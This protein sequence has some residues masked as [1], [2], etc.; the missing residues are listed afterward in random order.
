M[1][2]VR[3][4]YNSLR[5]QGYD[6][7][8][9]GGYFVTICTFDR[10]PI[11]GKIV[12][13]A[14]RL[15][16]GGVIAVECWEAIPEH[17]PTVTLDEFVVMPDHIHGIL[18][19]SGVRATPASPL[20]PLGPISDDRSRVAGPKARSLGVVVGSFKSAVTRR[21]NQTLRYERG[22][23]WQRNYFERVIRHEREMDEIRQYIDNNPGASESMGY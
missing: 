4:R 16:A 8:S 15:T 14:T 18:M 9:A 5:L 21:I 13:G 3:R 20:R 22:P 2:A 17:F 23:V 10:I 12:D 6:Y 7:A 19:F 11:F 1:G